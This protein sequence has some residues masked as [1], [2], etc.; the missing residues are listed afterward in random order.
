[1]GIGIFNKIKKAFKAV[2]GKIGSFAKRLVHELPKVVDVG[3]KVIGAV[4]PIISTAFPPAA[5]VLGAINTGLNTIGKIG[6][7]GRSLIDEVK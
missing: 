7:F 5:P 3:K 4:S 1:M 2:G 6:S